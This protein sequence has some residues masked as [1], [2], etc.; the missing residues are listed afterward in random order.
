MEKWEGQMGLVLGDALRGTKTTTRSGQPVANQ[1]PITPRWPYP[2]LFR[3]V[4]CAQDSDSLPRERPV[5]RITNRVT[6]TR[7]GRA[8]LML[9]CRGARA[10]AC[11]LLLLT[12]AI[13]SSCAGAGRPSPVQHRHGSAGAG[14]HSFKRL[15][16]ARRGSRVTGLGELKRYLDTFGYM[17]EHAGDH[18]TP[19]TTDD[20]FDERL[21]AAVKRYQSRLGLP[22]SGR[23]DAAT[24]DRIMSPRCGVE[25][26]G[27]SVSVA[28][29]VPPEHGG[30]VSRFSFFKG[31]P[32]WAR[33]QSESESDPAIVLTYAASPTATV[34]YL[35]PDA[36]R[37][38]LQRA[39]TRW[40]RVIPVSFVETDDYDAADI[41][42]G[43]YEGSHGDGV[44]FDG[45]LGVL[46]HAFSPKNGRLHLDA[47][48]RWAVDFGGEMETSSAID[49]ESVVTHEIGHVLGLGHSTSQEAVMY[50]S[51][52]PLQRKADLT[53][54]DV[55]GVQLLYGSNPDFRLSS[56]YNER[57]TSRSPARSSWAA[58]SGRLGIVGVVLVILVTQL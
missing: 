48:E 15:L 7:P 17:P 40:A 31:Q 1:G 38:V 12:A 4:S 6:V 44:P 14:W 39:F 29:G 47:S 55:E 33:P 41:K 35:P 54:D 43:F 56:L 26:H 22:V 24:L 21:E 30:A 8:A 20:A 3:Y 46:G 32:R 18:A 2:S 13:L 57:A 27:M 19:T 9:P 42:V 49:L 58:S 51:I 25:D 23:L 52:K 36:V 37:A 53:I 34:G 11:L 50:P 16:H 45:P 10:A 28:G 5:T